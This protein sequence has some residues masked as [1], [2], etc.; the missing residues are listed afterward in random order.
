MEV[1]GEGNRSFKKKKKNSACVNINLRIVAENSFIF[2]GNRAG[3]GCLEIYPIIAEESLSKITS[4]TPLFSSARG[5]K[6]SR[7]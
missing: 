7:M 1:G 6:I 4:P 3:L 2:F 5:A